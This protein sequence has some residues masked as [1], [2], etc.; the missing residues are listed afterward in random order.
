M[1]S[2]IK[3]TICNLNGEFV[4]FFLSYGWVPPISCVCVCVCVCVFGFSK[5]PL[6]FSIRPGSFFDSLHTGVGTR[7]T[8]SE[9]ADL[10]AAQ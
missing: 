8:A 9:Q 7:F 2:S 10:Q 5:S 3:V 6:G 4:A 1:I